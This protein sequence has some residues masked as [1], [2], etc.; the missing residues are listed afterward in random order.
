MAVGLMRLRRRKDYRPAYRLW[1][2]PVVPVLFVVASAV[3]VVVQVRAVPVD[4]A[5]GLGMVLV[6]LPVYLLW[7]RPGRGS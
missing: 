2:Y 1:A 4:S 6:G 3:V 7:S 5:I